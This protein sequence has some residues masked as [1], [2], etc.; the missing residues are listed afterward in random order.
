V[1]AGAGQVLAGAG[2]WLGEAGSAAVGTLTT[3]RR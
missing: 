1:L 3:G 2:D